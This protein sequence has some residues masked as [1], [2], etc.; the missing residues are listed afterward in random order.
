MIEEAF[1]GAKGW[2][3]WSMLD[4]TVWAAAGDIVV[5]TWEQGWRDRAFTNWRTQ[6]INM[7]GTMKSWVITNTPNRL[8]LQSQPIK[9]NHGRLSFYSIFV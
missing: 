6:G 2:T 4:G 1:E 8:F 5:D 3:S 9:K 7:I